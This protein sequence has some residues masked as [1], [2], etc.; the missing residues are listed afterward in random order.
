MRRPVLLFCGGGGSVVEGGLEVGFWH[1]RIVRIVRIVSS[2]GEWRLL[3]DCIF[4]IVY[5]RGECRFWTTRIVRIVSN[6]RE[7]RL[8]IYNILW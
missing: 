6:R 1:S 2:R 4:W 7:W 3:V 5:S 8:L